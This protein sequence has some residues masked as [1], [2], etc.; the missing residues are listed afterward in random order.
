M[1][2]LNPFAYKTPSPLSRFDPETFQF[3][4]TLSTTR[5][6][7]HGSQC[8]LEV[9]SPKLPGLG[10]RGRDR[11][12]PRSTAE[13]PA[14]GGPC[15]RQCGAGPARHCARPGRRNGRAAAA[16]PGRGAGALRPARGWRL[17]GCPGCGPAPPGLDSDMIRG[18]TATCSSVLPC[19]RGAPGPALRL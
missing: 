11:D 19:Q 16:G 18:A 12:R 6:K 9:C 10:R 5:S 13:A 15:A 14:P 17:S 7:C 8:I 2:K 4:R 1:K 3:G